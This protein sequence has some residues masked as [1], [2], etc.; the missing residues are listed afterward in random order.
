MYLFYDTET[1][2]V[3]KNW[4]APLSDTTNWPRMVQIAW[5]LFDEKGNELQ[6]SDYIIRPE[7]YTIPYN[8]VRIHG[9]S[10]Q[11]AQEK[12]VDLTFVL[13]EF[14]KSVQQAKVIVAHNISFDEKIVGAELMRKKLGDIFFMKQSFCTMKNTTHIC[15][16]PGKRGY[17]WPTLNELHLH[18]FGESFEN[19]HNALADIRATANCFWA[20]KERG[21]I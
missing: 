14:A 6:E 20:M 21:L 12:G 5:M 18:L 2:G 8:V 7:G 11:I 13:N 17:K 10:T 16:L 15:K 3:P 4:N 1:T 19:Q 9:I